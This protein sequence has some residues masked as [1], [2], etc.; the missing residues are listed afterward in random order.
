MTLPSGAAD[1]TDPAWSDLQALA[2]LTND[3]MFEL[4]GDRDLARS[5]LQLHAAYGERR[6]DERRA[7]LAIDDDELVGFVNARM[8][9]ADDAKTVYCFVAVRRDRRRRGI[10]TALLG[11]L[12]DHASTVGRTSLQMFVI[13]SADAGATQHAAATGHGGVPTTDASTQFLLGNAFTLEQANVGSVLALPVDV[14]HL[15]ALETQAH[16]LAAGYATLSWEAPTPAELRP[17]LAQL[18]QRM[19]T[20]LPTGELDADEQPWDADR[21]GHEETRALR[22]GQRLLYA[23]AREHS[24][25]ELVAYT[26]IRLQ[27]D[28]G[29]SPDQGDTLVL[30]EH[31]GHRLGLLVKIANLR[32]LAG[33]RPHA[34]RI[35]TFNADEN[36]H[37]RSINDVLGFTPEMIS[38]AWQKRLPN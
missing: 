9:L 23:A 19:S 10:A 33:A 4:E 12:I 8:P 38:G 26:E 32:A 21:V 14:H 34:R 13:H 24:S 1:V 15:D 18:R 5:P 36:A 29:V 35:K 20:D 22:S 6:Y 16:D 27:T 37:M 11:H 31:R 17:G 2:A 25:G 3:I 7:W 28:P 30:R